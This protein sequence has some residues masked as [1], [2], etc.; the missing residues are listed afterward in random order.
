MIREGI[1][2]YYN[3]II[4][5]KTHIYG[6]EVKAHKGENSCKNTLIYICT[7]S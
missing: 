6:F 3:N 7:A 4:S 5:Q 2:N 1:Q